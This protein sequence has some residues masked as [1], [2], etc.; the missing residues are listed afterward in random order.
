MSVR[1]RPVS[2]ALIERICDT[3]PDRDP[4][5]PLVTVVDERWAYCAGHGAAPHEWR[6]VGPILRKDIEGARA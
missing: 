2:T 6:A 5:G 4:E 3:H 1:P